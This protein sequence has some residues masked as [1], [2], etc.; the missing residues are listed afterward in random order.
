MYFSNHSPV[1]EGRV[2]DSI[3]SLKK[4]TTTKTKDFTPV[5]KFSKKLN[6]SV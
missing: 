2:L 4:K 5:P 6:L 1:K 3:S